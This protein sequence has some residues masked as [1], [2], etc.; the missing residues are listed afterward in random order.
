MKLRI[1][2]VIERL[3]RGP[4]IKEGRDGYVSIKRI[5][6]RL[7]NKSFKGTV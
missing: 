1:Y 2:T 6:I 4:E 3:K 7:R 5:E